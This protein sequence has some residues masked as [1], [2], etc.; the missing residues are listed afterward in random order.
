MK[1]QKDV[2]FLI[3]EEAEHWNFGKE[4]VEKLL[5]KPEV[6]QL[7]KELLEKLTPKYGENSARLK[8]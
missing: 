8:L 7:D 6:P 3:G 4:F 2:P 5:Q 1:E